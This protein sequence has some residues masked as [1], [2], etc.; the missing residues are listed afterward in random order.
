MFAPRASRAA[1]LSSPS[2]KIL[3]LLFLFASLSAVAS[4]REQVVIQKGTNGNTQLR[5]GD[6]Y[7][8]QSNATN[9]FGSTTPLLVQNSG[10]NAVR[11]ALFVFDLSVLPNVGVKTAT[12]TLRVVS[13]PSSTRTYRAN[14]VTSLWNETG[15]SWSN[16]LNAAS[17]ST[18]WGAAGG[19][20]NA[21]IGSASNSASVTS[22]SATLAF[23]VTAAV[24]AWY[25]GGANYGLLVKDNTETGA[26]V[27]TS[28]S[29]NE[30]ATPANRPQLTVTYLQNVSNLKAVPG[31]GSIALTW[32]NPT[33]LSNAT[34]LEA[35]SG[36]VILRRTGV[37]VDK[38]SFPADGT[39]PS[40]LCSTVGKGTVVF[41]GSATATSFTDNSSDTCGAPANGTAYYY[42]VFTYDSANNYSSNPAGLSAPLDGG[43]TYTAE[44]GAVPNV[45]GSTQAPQWMIATHSSTLAPPA[46]T[47]GSQVDIGSDTSQI[48]V[49]NS[50][51]GARLYSNV[52]LGG[53]ITGR[54]P[55]LDSSDA[56]IGKQIEYVACQDGY[57]YAIDT[58]TGQVVWL[59]EPGGLTTNA[60]QGGAG[61]AVKKFTTSS[62]TLTDDLVVVGTR[63]GATTTAN[64]I[65]GLDGNSGTVLWT[66]T[67]ST[68]STTA[69]DLISSTPLVDYTHNAIW[70]TSHS[71]GGSTQPNLWKLNPNTGAV[72]FQTNL[73]GADIDSSPVLSYNNDVVFV[74][75]N[76]SILYAINPVTGGA[77]TGSTVAS[78]N[79]NDGAIRGFPFVATSVA[80]YTIIISTA[81]KV[82]AVSYNPTTNTFTSLWTSPTISS[83][84][85]PLVA[86]SLA[87]VY[88]GTGD[89]FLDELNLSNGALNKQVIVN[90]FYPAV[91]GDPALDTVSMQ[92]YASTTTNDQRAY[93]FSI[94]F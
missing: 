34:L 19:D 54:S 1:T 5:G 61:V 2:F 43:S 20:F 23:T 4:A 53:I 42:K 64:R 50:S 56:S 89:G 18:A 90:T 75:N 76:N 17:A 85:A 9:N 87:K 65:F 77:V 31:N 86:F 13:A 83:P 48:F 38:A 91:V 28:F 14:Y 30:D 84:S 45:A 37:P 35:Y 36:V 49:L 52:S 41:V 27:P 6:T 59:T 15:A 16:R 12:L 72:L 21:S 66:Y 67:G 44:A 62:Y 25:N 29:S 8:D 80:P 46:L 24:Q 58:A 82:Q 22:G 88:V 74:G 60:F 93:A 55:I 68:G 40:A 78:F 57:V 94:P 70:V 7:L 33:L 39:A 73:G 3:A 81:T 63:N 47:P 71:N 10:S 32:T 11:R 92:I 79:A 51:T 26:S 69:L